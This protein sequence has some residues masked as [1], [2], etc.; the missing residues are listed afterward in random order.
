MIEFLNAFKKHGV[1]ALFIGALYWMH[2]RIEK[3]EQDNKEIQAKLYDCLQDAAEFNRRPVTS[4]TKCIKARII[5]ALKPKE[6][7][8]VK[9]LLQSNA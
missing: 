9:E 2:D 5:Y 6:Q 8:D 7:K 3:V 1:T 4:R